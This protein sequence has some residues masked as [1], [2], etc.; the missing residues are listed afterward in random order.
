MKVQELLT[1]M[2]YHDDANP[3]NDPE[4]VDMFSQDHAFVDDMLSDAGVENDPAFN[5]VIGREL[6]VPKAVMGKLEG[7]IKGGHKAA[8]ANWIAKNGTTLDD[9]VDSDDARD[10]ISDLNDSRREQ[11]RSRDPYKYHG[12]RKSDF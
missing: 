7:T 3:A 10:M 8:V 1:E 11:V 6:Y 9:W 5:R 12:V 4:V 2:D